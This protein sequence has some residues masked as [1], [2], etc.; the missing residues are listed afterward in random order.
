M[1]NKK[2]NFFGYILY[3]IT[4]KKKNSYYNLY[5][6][7][8]EKIISEEHLVRNHLNIYNLLKISQQ[9]KFK[10]GNNYDINGLMLHL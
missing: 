2:S 5:N 4:C 10:R 9:S 7:F 3:L 1:T 8:R 6:D